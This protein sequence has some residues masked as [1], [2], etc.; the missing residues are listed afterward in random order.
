LIPYVD[1]LI[2]LFGAENAVGTFRRQVRERGFIEQRRFHH[3]VLR[4]MVD[5]EVYKFDLI[6]A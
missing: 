4:K 6:G 3:A 1:K 5:E 2:N